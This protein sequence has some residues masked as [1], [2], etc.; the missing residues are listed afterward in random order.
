M[1]FRCLGRDKTNNWHY[2]AFYQSFKG[3]NFIACFNTKMAKEKKSPQQQE[4]E[5]LSVKLT[6]LF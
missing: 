3:K 1:P 2:Y 4:L 6:R 5:S